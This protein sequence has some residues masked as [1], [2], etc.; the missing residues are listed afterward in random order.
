[1]VAGD[2]VVKTVA[3]AA[4]VVVVGFVLDDVAGWDCERKAREGV[5]DDGCAVTVLDEEE[6]EGTSSVLRS[7]SRLA[8]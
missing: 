4:V 1:M 3:A 5:I 7:E 6:E 8:F 2:V